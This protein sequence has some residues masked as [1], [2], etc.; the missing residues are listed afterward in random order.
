MPKTI[1]TQEFTLTHPPKKSKKRIY[2]ATEGFK[3][4]KKYL[5][6]LGDVIKTNIEL[7]SRQ[8]SIDG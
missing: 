7:V 5:K 1:L 3:T 8:S 2:I 4:E 6:A